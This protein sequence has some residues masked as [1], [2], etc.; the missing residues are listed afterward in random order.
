M[1]GSALRNLYLG[2]HHAAPKQV[3][4]TGGKET[5]KNPTYEQVCTGSTD[6]AEAVRIEFD[7]EKVT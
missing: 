7:A 3:G 5:A 6:H 2:I 4:Y 1:L